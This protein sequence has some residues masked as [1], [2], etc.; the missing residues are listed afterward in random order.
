MT[1]AWDRE[2]TLLNQWRAMAMC[3][4]FRDAAQTEQLDSKIES[5][6]NFRGDGGRARVG[7]WPL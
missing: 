7:R 1:E 5:K 3:F 2:A 6:W 4:T